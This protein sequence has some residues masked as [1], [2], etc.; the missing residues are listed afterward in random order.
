M[1]YVLPSPALHV[2]RRETAEVAPPLIDKLNLT[3][4]S[5]ARQEGRNG[6]GHQAKLLVRGLHLREGLTHPEDQAVDHQGG[7]QEDDQSH[8]IPRLAN[9]G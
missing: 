6:I 8:D 4:G 5:S 3:V 2:L 9:W 1:Q 7:C